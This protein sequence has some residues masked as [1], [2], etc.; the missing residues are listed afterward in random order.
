MLFY[1]FDVISTYFCRLWRPPVFN[2]RLCMSES[3][4]DPLSKGANYLLDS[5]DRQRYDPCITPPPWF[6]QEEGYAPR[7]RDLG[8]PPA[9]ERKLAEIAA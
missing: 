9:V 2:P 8:L 5:V 4:P 6:L 3:A 7:R 1:W